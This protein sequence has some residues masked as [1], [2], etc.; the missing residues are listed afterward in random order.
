MFKDLPIFKA[1]FN[2]NGEEIIATGRRKYFYIYNIEGDVIERP[3]E[4]SGFKNKTLE[5]FSIS[6]CGQYVAF[7]G[8]NG[9]IALISY[10]TKQWITNLKMNG[11]VRSIDWSSDGQYLFSV[12]SD[13]EVYQWD[14]G[15]RKCVHR[16][17]D[18]GAFK[19]TKISIS[20]NDYYYATG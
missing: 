11:S 2:P 15:M 19:P 13:G 14:V 12:G 9:Y 10:K 8:S 4:I 5:N 7:A 20:K 16:F 17:V 3:G 18:Y 1:A 6:P